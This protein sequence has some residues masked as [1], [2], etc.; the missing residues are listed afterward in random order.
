M[1]INKADIQQIQKYLKGELDARAMHALEKQAHDDPFLMDAIEGYE[2]IG[3]NQ[4]GNFEELAQRFNKRHS[5]TNTPTM[6]LWRV[7]AVAATLLITLG[8]G[9]LFFRT[10]NNN[11]PLAK[12]KITPPSVNKITT[13]AAPNVPSTANA[14]IAHAGIN[15]CITDPTG[16]ALAGVKVNVKG[17]KLKAV[18][19]TN[20]VFNIAAK[21]VKGILNVAY[22]GY[23]AKQVALNGNPN[24]KVVLNETANQLATV[25]IT[26]YVDDDKPLNKPHPAIGW[27][28]F[29][30]YLRKNAFVESG[31]TGLVKLAFTVSTDGMINGMHVINGKNELM[32]QRA[33]DLVL[34]G[35]DW[36]SVDNGKEM[37]I[38]ILFR[39]VKE[40]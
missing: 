9:F 31:E 7:V 38:K 30:D 16:H 26:A 11:A 22:Y 23:E 13:P 12:N 36:K 20:G 28:A 5:E 24:L 4:Q 2:L 14:T 29:R 35:P 8:A 39:R 40:S 32:N 1:S 34:N 25:S 18:T 21:P 10:G 17:T 6:V 37:R 27:K 3:T 19:D 33:I 15:G